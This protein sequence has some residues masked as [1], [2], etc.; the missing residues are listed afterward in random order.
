[1]II[2]PAIS[3]QLESFGAEPWAGSVWRIVLGDRDPMAASYTGGRWSVPELFGAL[4]TSLDRHGSIAEID[5]VIAR[6]SIPPRQPKR[7]HEI[8]ISLM[9]VVDLRDPERL[10]KLGIDLTT[11]SSDWGCAPEIGAAANLLQMQG[12]IVPSVRH[13]SGNLVIFTDQ[14]CSECRIDKHS[15]EELA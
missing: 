2:N 11:F 13:L 3:D 6:F 8:R 10:Q 15:E 9:R 1:L 14:V 4:Y 5:A 7:L 12:I